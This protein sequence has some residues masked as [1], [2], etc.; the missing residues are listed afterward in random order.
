MSKETT[1]GEKFKEKNSSSMTTAI[2]EKRPQH[3]TGLSYKYKNK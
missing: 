3:K 1:A 2:E